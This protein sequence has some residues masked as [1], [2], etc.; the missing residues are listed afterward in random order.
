MA[1][2]SIN[3]ATG[4]RMQRFDPTGSAELEASLERA[5]EAHRA[6]RAADAA[7]RAAAFED[8]AD[9]LRR[10]A[11]I[12]ERGAEAFGRIMTLEMGKPIAQAVAEAR[13]CALACRHYADHGPAYL[14]DRA[15]DTDA[16]SS[17]V[18][19]EPLGP[20][21][22]I[23]PWNFPFWQVIR[24]AA[25]AVMAGNVGL[26]KHAPNVPQCAVALEGVFRRAGFPEGTLQNL[27]LE[28]DRV[29]DLMADRRVRAVTLTGSV[30]A[31]RAVAAGAG[32]NLKKTVLELG[33]SDPFV[34]MES[35]DL[36][37][38]L[39]VAVQARLQ[40]NG[41]S[42]IAA[43]RFIVAEPVADA[44]RNGLVERFGALSV[45]DPLDEETD[46]GPL[47]REDLRERLSDQVRR[48]VEAGAEVLL[49]GSV[50][51]GPGWFYEPTVLDRIPEGSPART[52]ELFGPVASLFRVRDA[53][54]ALRLAN[55]SSFGLGAS[56][57]TNDEGERRLFVDGLEAGNVAINGMV[58]SDPRLPF[59][60]IKD[61]GYGRELGR[62][63]IH[64]FVNVKSVKVH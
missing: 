39:E 40:N 9:R 6:A 21:L 63:G 60:G 35:A 61:S 22:A 46:V 5:V 48:T 45:G 52:E 26:L 10:A 54:E 20:V 38:A 42:C 41:E 62:E 49:G 28:T 3:P 44:F 17:F 1:F 58:A 7:D 53:E 32:R 43:K 19:Y 27:F 36:E 12:L 59:G 23:M 34:V 29:P 8:R 4:E 57:W 56:A 64:E 51:D 25:P 50:P 30:A 14:A 11:D 47:A 2:E 33:G 24:F 31:G 37:R 55:D 18:R 16:S 15:V 13:K